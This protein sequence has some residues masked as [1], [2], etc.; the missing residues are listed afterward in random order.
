[1]TSDVADELHLRGER[2]Q[3]IANDECPPARE[4]VQCFVARAVPRIPLHPPAVRD[5]VCEVLR[6]LHELLHGVLAQEHASLVESHSEAF[7]SPA[8]A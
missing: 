4:L 8:P 3:R 6:V 5:A 1:M 7:G 2:I